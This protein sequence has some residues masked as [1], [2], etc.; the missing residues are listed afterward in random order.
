MLAPCWMG[1]IW[2]PWRAPQR[3]E[4][5]LGGCFLWRFAKKSAKTVP[6]KGLRLL[7]VSANPHTIGALNPVAVG[8][9]DPP[10][11]Y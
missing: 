8:V 6:L 1:W 5:P 11:C 7:P 4:W 9:S 3:V 2:R 10:G